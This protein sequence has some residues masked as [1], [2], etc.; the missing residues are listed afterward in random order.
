[1]ERLAELVAEDEIV[2]GPRRTGGEL[3]LRLARPVHAQHRDRLRIERQA[4]ARTG[5][6]RRRPDEALVDER[7]RP[8]YG[9]PSLAEVTSD[10]RRPRTSPRGMPVETNCGT[11]A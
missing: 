7:Q 5:R 4:A 2:V 8:I 1:V 11:P 3:L 6:L 10:Q 9:D